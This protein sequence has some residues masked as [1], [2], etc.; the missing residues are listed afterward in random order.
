MQNNDQFMGRSAFVW[1]QGVVEDINDPLKLG[2]CRVRILGFHNPDKSQIPTEDLPWAF[3]VQPTT[4]AAMSGIGS[5]PTGL[6]CGSWVV[7]WFRDGEFAQEPI[8]MGSIPGI[9]Q[10][11][12]IASNGFSDP[13]GTYPTE[14]YIG[15]ADTNRLA[16]NENV[17]KTVVNTKKINLEPSIAA[18]LDKET[19]AEPE[20]QY[21][22][23]YPKNHVLQT[24]SGHIQEFDDTP[25]AERIHTYHKS[26]TF[27][28][29]YPDGSKVQKI[30]GK[31]Y[32]IILSDERI[33]IKGKKSENVVGEN[34]LKVGGDFNIHVEGNANILVEGNLT[35]ETRGDF[36]HKVGGVC[37]IVSDGNMVFVA[38]RIDLNPNG[39]ESSD[40]GTIF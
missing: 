22:A 37:A 26:G 11:K 13:S 25:N 5:S 35:Q 3:S 17:S 15:E 12:P 14:D 20:S 9:P 32:D 38:P 29:F 30:V 28:E 40:V 7:G 33:L 19:W 18:A 27:V 21:N 1:W 4:S 16:R 31:N 36:L 10:E 8:I 34:N 23:V 2:R 24:E 6:L 39:T